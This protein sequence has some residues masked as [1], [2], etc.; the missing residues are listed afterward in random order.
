MQGREKE[1]EKGL[2]RKEEKELGA[3]WKRNLEGHVEG[4]DHPNTLHKCIAK[5]HSSK[6][7]EEETNRWLGST[8]H[9]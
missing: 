1:E 4:G 2:K 5:I 8:H 3:W 7:K 9:I 6:L